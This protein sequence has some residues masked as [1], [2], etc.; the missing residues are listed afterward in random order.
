[1]VWCT[2]FG[3]ATEHLSGLVETDEVGKTAT[4]GT[5]STQ[6]PGLWRIELRGASLGG[7]PFRAA[8]GGKAGPLYDGEPE[9]LP[10]R[11]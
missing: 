5:R 11:H 9:G 10:P 7:L 1:I 6:E 8:A 2:G 3:Y 4:N